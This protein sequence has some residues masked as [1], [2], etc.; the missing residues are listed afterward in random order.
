MYGYI[1][2]LG[3]RY[4]LMPW[5][6]NI[7]LGGAQSLAPGQN[8]LVYDTG[9]ANLGMIY[10]TPAFLRMYW[11]AQQILINSALNISLTTGR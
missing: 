1:S 11:R 9:D 3:T 7:D 2:P 4:T 8:L 10:K 5:D 6:L